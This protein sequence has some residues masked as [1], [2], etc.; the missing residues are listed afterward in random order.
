MVVPKPY[1]ARYEALNPRGVGVWNAAAEEL[2]RG[3]SARARL[4]CTSGATAS[5]A[6]RTTPIK[7][8]TH[9]PDKSAQLAP[10]FGLRA[11]RPAIKKAT[12]RLLLRPN[13]APLRRLLRPGTRDRASEPHMG[14]L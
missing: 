11:A 2:R 5:H 10:R 4:C 14:V 9:P 1:P 13:A 8:E 12:R 3:A 6:D 7:N